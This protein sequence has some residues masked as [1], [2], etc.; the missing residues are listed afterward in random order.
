MYRNVF[1]ISLVLLA[2][3]SI[4][5]NSQSVFREAFAGVYHSG[6]VSQVGIGTDFDRKY[7][8]EIRFSAADV[9]DQQFGIEG[10]FSRNWVRDDWF[11]FHT[12][13]MLGYYFHEYVRV[14]VPLGFTIKPI[15]N[16]RNFAI[17]MEAT[18]NIF[19]EEGYANLRANIGV[20]YSF[21]K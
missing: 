4:K 18:P 1:F 17:L 19:V 15:E 14:G 10:Q 16:H 6:I 7:Y 3:V 5:A 12:G 11:N 9:L 21:G 20:R 13:L 8:G 2:G